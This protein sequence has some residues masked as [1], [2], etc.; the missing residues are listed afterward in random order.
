MAVSQDWSG[1]HARRFDQIDKNLL[2]LAE[3]AC[4]L[5]AMAARGRPLIQN[6][7]PRA[8]G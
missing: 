4:N 6:E 8:G 5:F 7:T 2:K 3:I 1:W